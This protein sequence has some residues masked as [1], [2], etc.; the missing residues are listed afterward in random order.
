LTEH[1]PKLPD[2]VKDQVRGDISAVNEAIVSEDSDKISEAL[3]RLKNSSMEIGK[4]IYSQGDTSE[5]QE[6]SS[7]E[8][9]KEEEKSEE[10]KTEEEKKE[11][12][13]KKN[14]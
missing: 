8:P 1:G 14:E 13:K 2:N 3:E 9:Q 10:D 12:E 11:D 7:E 6:E 5:N 4:A